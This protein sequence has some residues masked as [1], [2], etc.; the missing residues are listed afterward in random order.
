M[1]IVSILTLTYVCYSCYFAFYTLCPQE[2]TLKNVAEKIMFRLY[3]LMFKFSGFFSLPL[4]FRI[5]WI[6]IYVHDLDCT[7]LISQ[8]SFH[9]RGHARVI[10]LNITSTPLNNKSLEPNLELSL[11]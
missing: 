2:M 11:L 10:N 8:S 7:P 9:M 1:L 3:P 5:I 6:V 4:H